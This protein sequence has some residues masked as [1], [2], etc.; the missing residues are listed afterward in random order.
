MSDPAY[1]CEKC[2]LAVIVLPGEKPIRACNCQAP[3]V[4]A[5]TATVTEHHLGSIG[6]KNAP[7]TR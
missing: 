2:K 7:I 4:A 3:I 5:M 6:G 1:Y